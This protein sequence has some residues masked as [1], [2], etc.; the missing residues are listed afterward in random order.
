MLNFFSLSGQNG[1][2]VREHYL[3]QR[4]RRRLLWIRPG[5]ILC[6][7]Q[8][9]G[10][11]AQPLRFLRDFYCGHFGKQSDFSGSFTSYACQK[12]PRKRLSGQ[13]SLGWSPFDPCLS[14]TQSK[15]WLNRQNY[16][17]FVSKLILVLGGQ[18]F[19]I[20][21]DDGCCQLQNTVLHAGI[22]SC[23]HVL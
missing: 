15:I 16:R 14:S 1:W 20:Y 23:I 12:Q 5:R 18:T 13:F 17:D 21:V 19:F 3:S 11:G 9:V 2:F 6:H 22:I 10:I 8:L 4:Y 7:L